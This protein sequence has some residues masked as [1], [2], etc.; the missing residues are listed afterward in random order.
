RMYVEKKENKLYPT[1]TGKLVW[2]LLKENF[3]SIFEIKFTAGMEENLDRIEEG[4]INW[5]DLLYSF[6]PGFSNMLEKA[7]KNMKNIKKEKEK[8]TDILCEKCGGKMVIREGKYGEFLACKNFPKC[9][10]AKPIGEQKERIEPQKAGKLCPRCNQELVIRFAR[11]QKFLGCSSY[12][13]CRY[14]EQL[15][16]IT[17]PKC[18]EGVLVYRKSKRGG[19][20][21]CSRYPDCTYITNNK[22]LEEKCENCNNHLV[23]SGKKI[24][25]LNCNWTREDK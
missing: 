10:N 1:T 20:Y 18:K 12:P 3:P 4:G 16:K 8:E 9:R 15:I 25:C 7:E 23:Q 21:G 13:D 19:F 6:Y 5:K 2:G 24:F 11:G 17:C 22:F 14:T